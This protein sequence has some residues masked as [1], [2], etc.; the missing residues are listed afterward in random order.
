MADFG[1]PNNKAK[2]EILFSVFSGSFSVAVRNLEGDK[3]KHKTITL[4]KDAISIIE[5]FCRILPG[6]PPETTKTLI[7]KSRDKVSNSWV[8]DTIIGFEKNSNGVYS[9]FI[10]TKIN[11]EMRK[12]SATFNLSQK[13]SVSSDD[14]EKERSETKFKSF[15]NFLS[16]VNDDIRLGALEKD[17]YYSK[18]NMNQLLEKN[19]LQPKAP[20]K[21]TFGGGGGGKTYSKPYQQQSAPQQQP[22]AMSQKVNPDEYLPPDDLDEQLMNF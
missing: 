6:A 5:G 16:G 17:L 8:V 13:Y 4:D 20:Q 7:V 1:L 15:F 22:Q 18:L 10:D 21:K 14:S 11:N 12:Y 3:S 19:G 9:I 2:Y